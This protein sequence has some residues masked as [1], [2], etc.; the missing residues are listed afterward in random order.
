MPKKWSNEETLLVKAAWAA[1]CELHG[2]TMTPGLLALYMRVFEDFEAQEAVRAIEYAIQTSKWFP[3]PAELLDTLRGSREEGALK[4]WLILEKTIQQV[5]TWRSVLFEDPRMCA[6][7]KFFGG[8][9][10]VGNWPIKEMD[11]RRCEFIK[12]YAGFDN[13]PPSTMLPGA[14]ERAAMAT[15]FPKLFGWAAVSKAGEITQMRKE[16][17]DNHSDVIDLPVPQHTFPEPQNQIEHTGGPL[18][19]IT[20]FAKQL[21]GVF[22]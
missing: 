7:I 1:M 14:G 8:W 18:V 2:K 12:A 15:S 20:K 6:V 19:P 16:L 9:E 10:Q 4:A 11:Y 5:G 3:K 13:P 21:I 17:A 22:K